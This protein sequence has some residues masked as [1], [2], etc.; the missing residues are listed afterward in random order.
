MIASA[1]VLGKLV[2][3]APRRAGPGVAGLGVAGLDRAGLD[4]A[5]LGIAAE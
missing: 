3:D 4:R 2:P 1:E 5:K